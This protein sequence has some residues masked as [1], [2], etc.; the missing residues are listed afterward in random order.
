MDDFIKTFNG[1]A[2]HKH[3]YNVFQDFVTLSAISLYNSVYHDQEREQEYLSIVAQYHKD[4][5]SIFCELL[6]RLVMLLDPSP[7]DILGEL[8]M[9]LELGSKN[10]SQFFTPSNISEMMAKI[11]PYDLENKPFITFSDPTCGSGSMSLAYVKTL[12]DEGYNPSEKIWVQCIDID[13][14]VALMCY[15]QLALWNVP[16]QVLVGD[17]LTLEMREIW[18]TP[19]HRLGFWDARL[20]NEREVLDKT[21]GP[22]TVENETPNDQAE[23]PTIGVQ[24]ELPFDLG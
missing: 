2:Q 3:R 12:V 14:T 18:H 23:K 11:N 5:V 7:R 24:L 8:Y 6:G 1:L 13:R 15:L 10:T 20:R 16:A 19:A 4:E 9:G 21:D 17:S 22:M